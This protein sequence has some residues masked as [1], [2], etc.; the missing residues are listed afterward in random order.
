[1]TET[2]PL[3]EIDTTVSH[4]AR[5]WNYW[6]GG[7]DNY[8]VDREIG[9][10]ILGFIPELVHSARADRGCSLTSAAC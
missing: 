9:D 8:L 5:I 6:L 4:S 1:M 2:P 10:Q 3:G 7:K